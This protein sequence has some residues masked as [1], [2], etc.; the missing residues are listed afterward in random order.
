MINKLK[1]LLL[2]SK[3][4]FFSDEELQLFLDENDGKVYK[5]ASILC[6]LKAD[7]DSKVT[8]G[9][10][11]IESAG[12]DFWINLSQEYKN[13]SNEVENDNGNNSSNSSGYY[14][15]HMPRR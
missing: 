3:Y 14:I 6:H 2:E 4:P 5:T 7:G 1:I 11:T 12:A 13:K 15:N 8:V 10:I 9:P